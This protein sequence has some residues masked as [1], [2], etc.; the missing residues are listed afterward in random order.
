M[1]Y[2][3]LKCALG[4]FDICKFHESITTIKMVNVSITPQSFLIHLRNLSFLPP[5]PILRHSL[6][7]F[8][9]AFSSIF[10][11]WNW[12]YDM[13]SLFYLAPM[14]EHDYFELFHVS[15]VHSSYGWV[16]AHCM[17]IP[18]FVYPFTCWWISGLF[19]IFSC[20]KAAMNICV[21]AFIRL[22]FLLGKY[23]GLDWLCCVTRVC[24][25]FF[26]SAKLFSKM[27]VPFICPTAIYESSSSST[28]SPTFGM[29]NLFYFNHSIILTS[30]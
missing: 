18:E 21:I 8:L 10:H 19:F 1:N 6:T 25:K 11:A 17:A 29:V 26:K 28:S 16:V 2:T 20:H 12:S 4:C 22:A 15:I 30:V 7:Y 3:C 24:L 14:A 13:C 9:F 5:I 23:Q 27:F